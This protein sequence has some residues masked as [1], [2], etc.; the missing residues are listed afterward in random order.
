MK[1]VQSSLSF[2]FH[3]RINVPNCQ[4][5]LKCYIVKVFYIHFLYNANC[6]TINGGLKKYCKQENAPEKSRAFCLMVILF[7]LLLNCLYIYPSVCGRRFLCFRSA[8]FCFLFKKAG[9]NTAQHHGVAY[10][11]NALHCQLFIEFR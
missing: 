5:H 4:M 6:L 1:L 7:F 3:R 11:I 2:Y 8:H 10:C 9:I